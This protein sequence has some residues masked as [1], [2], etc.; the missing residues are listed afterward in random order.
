[1]IRRPPRSTPLYSSAASDVY[2]RQERYISR[3]YNAY[4][5]GAKGQKA[6]GFIMTVYRRRL[7]SSFVAIEL[8]LQRRLEALLGKARAIDLLT[9]D[10]LATLEDSSA[11]DLDA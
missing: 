2:K 9:P 4:M 7:T 10:D 1:M 5:S 11:I 6:L 8:S 3:Y